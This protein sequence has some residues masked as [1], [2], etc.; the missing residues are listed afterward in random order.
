MDLSV[1]GQLLPVALVA[2]A[3]GAAAGFE[4][5]RSRLGRGLL[6]RRPRRRRS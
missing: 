2:F 4:H 3:V 6:G 1:V 5:A